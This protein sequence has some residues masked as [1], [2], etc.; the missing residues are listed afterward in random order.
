MG[1]EGPVAERGRRIRR[2]GQPGSLSDRSLSNQPHRDQATLTRHSLLVLG[3][4]RCSQYT[5]NLC[6]LVLSRQECDAWEWQWPCVCCFCP[7]LDVHG[8]RSV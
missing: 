8:L 6:A 4:S 2:V 5:V 7:R 3:I 1:A